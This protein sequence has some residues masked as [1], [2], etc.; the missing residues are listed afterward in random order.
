MDQHTYGVRHCHN[1]LVGDLVPGFEAFA[2]ADDPE[3]TLWVST[4]R[5]G[6]ESEERLKVLA[7]WAQPATVDG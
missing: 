1:G 6:S 3:Q 2:P 7:S 4:V 5:P